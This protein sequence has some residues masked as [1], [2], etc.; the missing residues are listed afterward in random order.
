MDLIQH[1][2][3][4]THKHG[5]TFDLVISRR[6]DNLINTVQVENSNMLENECDHFPVSCSIYLKPTDSA[7]TE[8]NIRTFREA[9]PVRCVESIAV[10]LAETNADNRGVCSFPSRRGGGGGGGQEVKF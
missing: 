6:S 4:P 3:S 8:C 5:H 1:V 9:Y 2:K 7:V 10:Y